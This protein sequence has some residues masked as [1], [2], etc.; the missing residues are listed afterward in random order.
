MPFATNENLVEYYPT[1]MDHGVGNWTPELTQA[2]DDVETLIKSRWFNKEFDTGNRMLLSGSAAY[3]PNLLTESQWTRATCF[4]ALSCYILPKLS[5]FRPEGDA[6]R[7]QLNFFQS[8][9][10]EE[11]NLQ[12]GAGVEYDLNN[13]NIITEGEKFEVDAM[14]LYR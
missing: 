14:R 2:Q 11:F 4:R 13:D 6:F 1:A 5:T 8:R 7:E 9:F 12:L 3:N 10:E